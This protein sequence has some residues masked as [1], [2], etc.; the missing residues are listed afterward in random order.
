MKNVLTFA[1]V[2][3]LAV[4]IAIAAPVG[5]IKGYVKDATGA[6]VPGASI[7][8]ISEETNLRQPATTD[9]AGFYQF[10]QLPPGNYE[11]TAEAQGFRKTVVRHIRVAVD[12]IT[13]LDMSL[14]IGQVTDAVEVQG[15][16][17]QL[18]EG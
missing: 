17:A 12:Q 11:V 5:S 3:F 9:S 4:W 15:G 18:I 13:T 6:V 7:L 2:F 10:L 1:L 14:D 16:A 8:L